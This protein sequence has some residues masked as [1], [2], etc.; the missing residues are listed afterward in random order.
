MM[1]EAAMQDYNAN[2]R[3]LAS[4]ATEMIAL[5]DKGHAECEDENCVSLFGLA[6][7]CAYRIKAAAE[8]E[9]RQHDRRHSM[10]Q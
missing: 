5:A 10:T 6:K 2:V 7:D 1:K 9:C 8:A 4:I 3:Q